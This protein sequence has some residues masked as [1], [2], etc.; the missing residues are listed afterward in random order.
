[1]VVSRQL[2]P[3]WPNDGNSFVVAHF[4]GQW[5]LYTW[6]P[7]CYRVP[8]SA[9]MSALCRACMAHG[10]RAMWQAPEHIVQEF[11]L[12]QLTEKES[13]IFFREMDKLV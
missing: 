2:G 10:E 1:M 3:V 4:E 5:F 6:T 8:P 9:N 13:E 11:G 7:V 12:E